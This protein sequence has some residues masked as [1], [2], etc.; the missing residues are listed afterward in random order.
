MNLE[1]IVV[2]FIMYSINE[3]QY[4]IRLLSEWK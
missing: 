1:I 3:P 2:S 4:S